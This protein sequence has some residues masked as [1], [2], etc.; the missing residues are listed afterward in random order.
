MY[1]TLYIYKAFIR[2]VYKACTYTYDEADKEN[3]RNGGQLKKAQ[4][5]GWTDSTCTS[6][7]RTDDRAGT[8][9]GRLCLAGFLTNSCQTPGVDGSTGFIVL[10]CSFIK[11]KRLDGPTAHVHR[12]DALTTG[13]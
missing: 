6:T 8:P 9:Q 2:S 4:T 1:R 5:T 10:Y 3:Q 12:R 7:G 13:H 11:H